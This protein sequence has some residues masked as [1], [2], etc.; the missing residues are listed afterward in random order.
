MLYRNP[1]EVAYRSPILAGLAGV[2]MAVSQASSE[3]VISADER[4]LEAYKD[5][6]LGAFMSGMKTSQTRR[7]ALEGT[8]H[9]IR[10]PGCLT[11]DELGYVTHNVNDLIAESSPDLEELRFAAHISSSIS[12]S[13]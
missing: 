2:I 3:S 1:D 5:D 13:C 9:L 7:P 12:Q 4:P 10:V 11:A 8:M 6:V